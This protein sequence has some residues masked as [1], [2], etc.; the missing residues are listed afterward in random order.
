M[1]HQWDPSTQTY[2]DNSGTQYQTPNNSPWQHNSPA[3]TYQNGQRVDGN[4]IG[5]NFVPKK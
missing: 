5:G 4:I 2:R 3:T 1:S